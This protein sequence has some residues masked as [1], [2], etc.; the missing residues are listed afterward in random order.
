V[1]SG[2]L[3]EAVLAM[4]LRVNDE[5]FV[6]GTTAGASRPGD[7]CGLISGVQILAEEVCFRI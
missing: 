7:G 4:R 2:E 6:R 3:K 1:A 5:V